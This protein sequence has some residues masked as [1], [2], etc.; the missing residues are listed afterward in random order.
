M[1]IEIGNINKGVPVSRLASES[2]YKT[3]RIP[4]FKINMR[5]LWLP[6]KAGIQADRIYEKCRNEVEA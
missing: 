3:Y 6:N 2:A 1:A 4:N 5:G